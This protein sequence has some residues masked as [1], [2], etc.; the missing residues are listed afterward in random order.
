MNYSIFRFTLNMHNHRSQASVSAFRG[1]TAIRLCFNLTDGGLPYRI[2]DGCVAVLNGTKPD[3]N[4]L[5]NRC[6]IENNSTIVYDFTEQTSACPGI[7]NCDITLY[8]GDGRII[9]APKFIIVVD[10]REVS[11][12]IVSAT[13]KS[14]LDDVLTRAADIYTVAEKMQPYMPILPKFAQEYDFSGSVY[15]SGKSGCLVLSMPNNSSAEILISQ[16]VS[17]ETRSSHFRVYCT[18]IGHDHEYYVDASSP[19]TEGEMLPIAVVGSGNRCEWYIPINFV[20]GTEARVCVKGIVSKLSDVTLTF[21]EETPD[22]SIFPSAVP[23]AIADE[24]GN[25]ISTTYASKNALNNVEATIAE[26]KSTYAKQCDFIK[27]IESNG[28]SGYLQLTVPSN[29]G[30]AEVMISQPRAS[31]G[32]VITRFEI[33]S[34]GYTTSFIV[35]YESVPNNSAIPTSVGGATGSSVDY[36]NW[37]IPIDLSFFSA[38]VRVKGILSEASGVTIKFVETK[39]GVDIKPHGLYA[40]VTGSDNGKFMRVVD[41]RW[42]AEALTN[43]SEEGA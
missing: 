16:D 10:E 30:W 18:F 43:V 6:V 29:L 2:E 9:T 21:T 32:E 14:A 8:G 15:E 26:I 19:N 27:T 24:S 31:N 17:L 40:K 7:I 3:G 13:E 42:T 35:D 5:H 22:R 34:Y 11:D 33:Y 41:G 36:H 1:D 20:D 37:Y 38:T 25:K 12:E 28:K 4:K 23:R 39:A